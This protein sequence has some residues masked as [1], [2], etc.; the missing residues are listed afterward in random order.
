MTEVA[1]PDNN[2]TG[3]FLRILL[4]IGF[5]LII[6]FDEVITSFILV[7]LRK[8][9]L[10]LFSVLFFVQL[11]GAP[12][13]AGFSD[14]WCRKRTLLLTVAITTISCALLTIFVVEGNTY[15]SAII[16]AAFLK[17]ALG[18][19]TPIARAGI[20]DFFL[21]KGFRFVIGIST[22]AIAEGYFV[23][24]DTPFIYSIVNVIIISLLVLLIFFSIFLRDSVDK[25]K[26]VHEAN[27]K[28]GFFNKFVF[29]IREIKRLFL[30]NKK[31]ITSI[32]SYFFLEVSFYIIF[33][34]SIDLKYFS[35]FISRYL[36]V[37]YVCG[38]L[39]LI[40]LSKFK[41]FSLL[42]FG[43]G[44]SLVSSLAMSVLTFFRYTDVYAEIFNPAAVLIYS[45]G[46]GYIV[47]CMF[48]M[49]SESYGDLHTQGKLYGLIET[50]DSLAFIFAFFIGK[51]FIEYSIENYI[52]YIVSLLIF[53]L[54]IIVRIKRSDRG[55]KLH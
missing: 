29:E 48:S 3:L 21:S 51:L 34:I 42:K 45:F 30:L 38:V 20:V 47:P 52:V 41:D 36:I 18:N 31:F 26:N 15:S 2:K 23:Y 37:G 53:I 4:L 16:A 5:C 50:C 19:M 27:I 10:L 7:S 54:G 11:V 55:W 8:K 32:V 46:F 28:E 49:L 22:L 44:I 9:S 12:L 1:K 35:I 25:T 6:T 40:F 39:T 24:Q 13:Q 33:V 43:F 14:A 17:F